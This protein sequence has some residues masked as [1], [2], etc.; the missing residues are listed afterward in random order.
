MHVKETQSREP[1]ITWDESFVKIWESAVKSRYKKG[2]LSSGIRRDFVATDFGNRRRDGAK[3]I[4]EGPPAQVLAD[5][6]FAK[7][8]DGAKT[9]RLHLVRIAPRTRNQ[10]GQNLNIMPPSM[11]H[12]CSHHIMT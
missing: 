3:L 1:I 10:R 11:V 7:D 6:P 9:R 2:G 12:K 8:E 5:V 4:F